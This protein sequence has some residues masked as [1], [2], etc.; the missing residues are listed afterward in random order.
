VWLLVW[1]NE[2]RAPAWVWAPAGFLAATAGP[3]WLPL[4][5]AI[6]AVRLFRQEYPS[7]PVLG[8]AGAGALLGIVAASLRFGMGWDGLRVPP[9][10]AFAAG[11]DAPWSTESTLYLA[12]VY[13]LPLIVA[14]AAVAAYDVSRA[15]RNHELD[16]EHAEIL[17][18]AGV[19]SAWLAVSSGSKTPIP[20][21]GLSIPLAFLLGPAL[22]RVANAA[23]TADWRYARLLVPGML[24]AL[25]VATAFLLQWAR[26]G[27]SGEPGEQVAVGGLVVVALGCATLLALSRETLATLAVPA[28]VS[29][30]SR[31]LRAFRRRI[32]QPERASAVS[33]QP[34]PGARNPRYRPPRAPGTGRAHRRPPTVRSRP[35]LAVPQ[36]R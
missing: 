23:W 15:A 20:L 8:Y 24:A 12:V 26:D 33:G 2:P 35:H 21:V 14:G 7:V 27:R 31:A 9:F 13:L 17:A 18:W 10:D 5:L 25:V 6:G 30:T 22:A 29:R 1:L 4:A 28:A 36:V 16:A 19:A 32:V 11:F 34:V 3:A